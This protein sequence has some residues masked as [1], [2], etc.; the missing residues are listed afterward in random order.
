MPNS[1]VDPPSP[2]DALSQVPKAIVRA[3]DLSEVFQDALSA[4]KHPEKYGPLIALHT[5]ES[6]F[7][8]AKRQQRRIQR[9][10][11]SILRSFS[12]PTR[13][14]PGK[15]LFYDVHFYLICWAR[16]AK[17]AWFIQ[18]TTKF[19]RTGLVLRQFKRDLEARI[20]ARDHLEHFE[21]RLPGGKK[22]SKLAVPNDLVNMVNQHLTYGG[23]RI[24]IGPDSIRLLNTIHDEFVTALLFD[25]IEVLAE[26]DETRLSRLLNAAVSKV[27]IAQTTRNVTRMLKDRTGIETA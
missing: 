13:I 21:E 15:N 5:I 25:S 20:N 27:H 10:E 22:H 6:Y 18:Q 23:R 26:E 19:S 9:A 16:I 3:L 7:D 8:A 14:M 1:K 11:V 24:D 4:I 12:H 17:L 2:P